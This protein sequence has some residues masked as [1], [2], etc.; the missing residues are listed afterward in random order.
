MQL[1]SNMLTDWLGSL[2]EHP[3]LIFIALFVVLVITGAGAPITEEIITV[4]AGFLVYQEVLRPWWVAWIV[5]YVGVIIADSI[6][7]WLGWHFGKA[8]LQR[9][10]VKR[11]LH[12]RRL[13]WAKHHVQQHGAWMI[14]ACRF[15]P[16][17]RYPTLLITG[18]MHLP[19]WK[20]LTADCSTAIVTV[21]LHMF[22]G[23]YVARFTTNFEEAMKH[24]GPIP[25]ILAGMGVLIICGYVM[26]QRIKRRRRA[27]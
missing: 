19:R 22:I 1:L 5:I 6:T 16:G 18:M 13:L 27:A 23:W 17:T 2:S 9:R 24:E 3:V 26:V 7:V 21:S 15:I 25:L 4:F 12:P 8:V 14:V 20:F 10:W 11:L